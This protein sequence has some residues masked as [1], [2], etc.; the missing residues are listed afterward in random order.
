[1]T[2]FYTKSHNE[3]RLHKQK[4]LFIISL[5]VGLLFV[6]AS[7]TC[8]FVATR[9]T[10]ILMET[11][12]IILFFLGASSVFFSFFYGL[13]NYLHLRSW[14]AFLEGKEKE[15]FEVISLVNTEKT[16]RRFGIIFNVVDAKVGD[17]TTS[18]FIE[19]AMA[20]GLEEKG[21]R[22]FKAVNRFI[23]AVEANV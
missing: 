6:G 13:V 3:S 19:R 4:V 23:V 18:F 15:K 21:V 8:Y 22:S 12:A 17:K 10:K 20:S 7:V 16:Y 2:E 5:V 9:N 11:L 14:F 1:M